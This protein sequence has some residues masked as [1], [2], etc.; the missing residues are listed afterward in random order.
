[1][2][3][4][5]VMGYNLEIGNA[6][7]FHSK[8]HDELCAGWEIE[9]VENDDAPVA[10]NDI[11][12][13]KNIRW[14][15]YTA[16]N[17]FSRACGLHDLFF[18]KPNGLFHQHPGCVLLKQHHH[19]KILSALQKWRLT[20]TQPAGFNDDDIFDHETKKWIPPPNAIQ[21]DYTLAR[22]HW[23]EYWVKWALENCETPAFS[24]S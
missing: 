22:L 24:N 17:E 19:T 4:R 23:L 5:S 3:F 16:W 8:E 9:I 6:K 20:S 14:P 7:P 10:I 12:E 18:N 13:K 1:M 11:N 15:S 21:Y 2:L